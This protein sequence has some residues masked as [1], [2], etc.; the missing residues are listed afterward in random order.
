MI[1][2]RSNDNFIG[3]MLEDLERID[4]MEHASFPIDENDIMIHAENTLNSFL[5]T[6]HLQIEMISRNIKTLRNE[7]S[8]KAI[9]MNNN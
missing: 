7:C 2:K 1:D 8:I 9:S 5:L 4:A 3:S 6:S